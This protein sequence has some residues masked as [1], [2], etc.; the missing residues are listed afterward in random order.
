[1]PIILNMR[2]SDGDSAALALVQQSPRIGISASVALAI[3]TI[4]YVAAGFGA[5][6]VVLASWRDGALTAT[7][8]G[9]A[10]VLASLA[11]IA[12]RV[13]RVLQRLI[14]HG[15]IS[16]R[17]DLA[18]SYACAGLH[19]GFGAWLTWFT[20]IDPVDAVSN[21][22]VLAVAAGS[23]ATAAVLVASARAGRLPTDEE[24][25]AEA[26]A[27]KERIGEKRASRLE[28]K[29]GKPTV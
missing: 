5:I 9:V 23:V 18:A 22:V 28:A 17:L 21:L 26:A 8:L 24:L 3:S 20:I 10:A 11:F 4:E 19:L 15:S 6:G 25:S 14:E 12:F 27:V 29:A 16:S 13:S 2:G 1:M 7:T